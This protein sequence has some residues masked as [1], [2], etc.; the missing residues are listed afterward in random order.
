MDDNDTPSRGGDGGAFSSR[1][2]PLATST[3]PSLTAAAVATLR[4]IFAVLDQEQCGRL[5]ARELPV[6]LALADLEVAADERTGLLAVH[7]ADRERGLTEAEFVA[8]ADVVASSRR[9]APQHST[10]QVLRR[11]FDSMSNN[12]HGVVPVEGVLG[13]GE[14][15][16]RACDE[17]L[18]I[19]HGFEYADAGGGGGSFGGGGGGDGGNKTGGRRASFAPDIVLVGGAGVGGGLISFGDDPGS[20]D[21][22]T[23]FG[24]SN[25]GGDDAGRELR[26]DD[27]AAHLPARIKVRRRSSSTMLV[28]QPR[29]AADAADS[30]VGRLR[31][32]EVAAEQRRSGSAEG[33]GFGGGGG[34]HN[35]NN[36]RRR[37]LGAPRPLAA[38]HR[39]SNGA[40]ASP[41]TGN[42]DVFG[43]EDVEATAQWLLGTMGARYAT[44]SEAEKRDTEMMMELAR[45]AGHSVEGAAGVLTRDGFVKLML[46]QAAGSGG[47]GALAPTSA[48]IPI[49]R[50]GGASGVGVASGAADTGI[51]ALD[52]PRS[53]RRQSR[54]ALSGVGRPSM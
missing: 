14:E 40:S 1:Q 44:A 36:A 24:G 18:L 27:A 49:V 11:M 21:G 3:Y 17:C 53:G 41:G 46:E 22:V 2:N 20:D 37:S 13:W 54:L 25:D 9:D 45:A 48:S 26:F 31:L 42:A 12:E 15:V 16:L 7:C 28:P 8:I 50:S 38:A 33:G 47:R 5:H 51:S 29:S 35:N 6:A 43:A 39:D 52:A 34:R 30:P 19:E 23:S 32:P 4:D 10:E